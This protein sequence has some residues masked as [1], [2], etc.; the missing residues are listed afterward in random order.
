MQGHARGNSVAASGVLGESL[1]D[2][3]RPFWVDSP[4]L[5]NSDELVNRC[6]ASSPTGR[7]V[8]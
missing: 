2:S 5:H 7:Y 8:L 4:G 3:F 1:V 6:I